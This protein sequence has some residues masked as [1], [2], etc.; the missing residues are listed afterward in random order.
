MRI[1]LKVTSESMKNADKSGSEVFCLIHFK[2][3]AKDNIA[4]RGKQEIEEF[5]L[6]KKVNA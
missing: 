1:P 6:T 2:E 5:A 3:H 4:Y